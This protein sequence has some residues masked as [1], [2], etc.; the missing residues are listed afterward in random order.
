MHETI[1]ITK[2]RVWNRED[3]Y[4]SRLS[5]YLIYIGDNSDYTQ[6]PTCNNG[7]TYDGSQNVTCN[8]AGRY[9]TIELSGTNYLSLCEV[10]AYSTTDYTEPSVGSIDVLYRTNTI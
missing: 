7:Q 6:N 1:T 2:V 10:E 4:S 9:L 8:L 5:D 3:L